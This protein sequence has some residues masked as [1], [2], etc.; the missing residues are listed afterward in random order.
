MKHIISIEDINPVIRKA[1]VQEDFEYMPFRIVLDYEFIYCH[2][3]SFIIEYKDTCIE[4]KQGQIAIIPPDKIHR[5]KCSTY[6]TSYWVHFDFVQYPYQQQIDSIV[7][8]FNPLDIISNLNLY[9]IPRPTIEIIPNLQ[10]PLLFY[11]KDKNKTL[12]S[13]LSIINFYES[14]TYGWQIKCKQILLE[15]ILILLPELQKTHTNI[16]NYEHLM[17]NID[18]YINTNIYRPITVKEL[19]NY[20]HYHPDTLTRIFKSKRNQTLRS[21]IT[22]CKIDSSKILL[23]STDYSIETIAE[24]YGFTDRTYY[25]KV[26]K[27]IVGISPSKYRH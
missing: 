13:F 27:K 9:S 20:F 10:L 7:Q 2:K 26:F 6:Q 15:L 22:N 14:K 8:E 23:D 25:S 21:Y 24:I 11:V 19:A 1:G 12:D 3:G 18:K 4:V 17:S 16:T 5:F